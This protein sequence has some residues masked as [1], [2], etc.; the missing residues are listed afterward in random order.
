SGS[1]YVND[2]IGCEVCTHGRVIG[3]VRDVQATGEDAPGTPLLVIDSPEGELLIPL[4]Q[5]ICVLVDVNSRSIEVSLPEGLRD[6]N[7]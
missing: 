3:R 5:E 6:L 1:Y 7:R 4:A 2:L